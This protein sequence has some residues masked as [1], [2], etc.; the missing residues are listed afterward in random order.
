[1]KILLTGGAGFIGSAVIR[2][3]IQETE[4]L[5]VNLDKLTY[6]GNLES[7]LSVSDSPKYAF[8]QV[9]ICDR[10]ELDRVFSVHKPDAVM[11]LAAESHVDR[12]IDGP[13][14]FIETNIV[15]TYTLLEATRHYWLGLDEQKKLS[16]RFHHIST[17]EVYG[18]LEGTT[19]L[20][21]ETTSYAPSSPYSASKASSDHLV[22]A[23]LRTYGLPTIV[24]NCSNNYGPYHFPEKLIPLVI[25]NSLEN[26]PLPIYGKGDQIR[27]WLYVEDHAR[28]L[29]KVVTEGKIG[30]TYNIGGHNEKQNLEVVQTICSILDAL[31]P[32]N[33][34]YADQIIYVTDRPGHDH[35][36]AIDATKMSNELNW[37][38]EETFET[39]LRKTIEWYLVNQEWCKHVQ[40]GTYQRGRLGI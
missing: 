10:A 4:D 33:T 26:K 32:K 29:Y 2:H 12:S 24:T 8:E 1:M 23:W 21:T 27:D 35:R 38:P 34:P 31:V 3:I 40:D 37:Q 7:L 9:N 17:D 39:G 28:A 19:D 30:E 13:A 20:F 11:H 14:A 18:D 36:Y 22:R 5:V 25:L 16:F 15:G 6:A